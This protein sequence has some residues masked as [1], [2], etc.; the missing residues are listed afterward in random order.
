VVASSPASP[1]EQLIAATTAEAPAPAR[2]GRKPFYV[3]VPL[4]VG[5]LVLTWLALAP[6]GDLHGTIK[7]PL[8]L[9]GIGAAISGLD[10]VAN[11]LSRRRFDTG[12]WLCTVWVTLLA[13]AAI[14]ADLLPLG[15]HQDASKTLT[16]PRLLRPDLFSSHPLGTNNQ[17]LDLLAQCIYG[18]RVSLLTSIFAVALSI[19]V[20]TLIGMLAGYFRGATDV[21]I[22]VV[23]DSLLAFPP[24]ILLIALAAVFGRPDT[25]SSAVIK[26]GAALA[27]VGI[28]TM[29]RLAR[30]NTMMFAQREFVLASRGMGAKNS[31]IL[32]REILPNVVLPI[33]SY[34]FIIVAVL[35]IAEGSLSFLGLGL[36]QPKPTWGNMIAQADLTTLQEDPHIALVPGIFMFI[37]VYAF[38]RIGERARGSWDSRETKV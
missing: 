38:N 18:A 27:I 6:L 29:V 1:A 11:G 7:V 31:R 13:L 37:T 12:F 21:S 19:V 5:G 36:Q 32:F 28:P 17:S 35:I 8:T 33:V 3:G 10:R 2:S 30:A 14:F 34:A 23:N 4:L 26:T 9:I 20:G 22:G 25:T 15:E 16:D 24:L